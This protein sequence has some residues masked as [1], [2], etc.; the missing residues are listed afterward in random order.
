[1]AQVR[2]WQYPT[3]MVTIALMTWRAGGFYIVT[4][5]LAN[6]HF[7]PDN[8][9]FSCWEI[10]RT[11]PSPQ[12][13]IFSHGKP[14]RFCGVFYIRQQYLDFLGREPDQRGFEY[15]PIRST[16][17]GLDAICRQSKRIEV[18]NAFFKGAEFSAERR[19]PLPVYKIGLA[20]R[21]ALPN[22]RDTRTVIGR[23][24]SAKL[25]ALPTRFM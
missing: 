24:N 10:V 1:M 3:V 21:Q 18:A 2:T 23:L 8:R 16:Q 13:L 9:S 22:C 5:A 11:Q 17:C 7:A 6:F 25:G 12:C 14:Y 15:W 20:K 19:V 4:P